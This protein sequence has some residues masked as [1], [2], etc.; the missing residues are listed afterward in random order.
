MGTKEGLNIQEIYDFVKEIPGH[1][2]RIIPYNILPGIFVIYIP[3]AIEDGTQRIMAY[4]IFGPVFKSNKGP[5]LK[6]KKFQ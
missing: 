5:F 6:F 1:V 3:Y 2:T 4:K